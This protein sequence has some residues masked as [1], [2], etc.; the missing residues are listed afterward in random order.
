[1]VVLA[2]DPTLPSLLGLRECVVWELKLLVQPG[3]RG[4]SKGAMTARIA[5]EHAECG[6]APGSQNGYG[7]S[8][9]IFRSP[10]GILAFVA[11]LA[12][13]GTVVMGL[14]H[15]VWVARFCTFLARRRRFT[16]GL[17]WGALGSWSLLNTTWTVLSIVYCAA[18]LDKGPSTLTGFEQRRLL[19]GF[20]VAFAWA[21]MPQHMRFF[22]G[23]GALSRTMYFGAPEIARFMVGVA[24]IFLAFATLITVV[25]GPST[26]RWDGIQMTSLTMFAVATGDVMRETFVSTMY[27]VFVPGGWPAELFVVLLILLFCGIFMYVVIMATTAM[28]EETFLLTRPEAERAAETKS[29]VD[30]DPDHNLSPIQG[31]SKS[32]VDEI[33]KYERHLAANS[34]E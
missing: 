13:A 6:S 17:L 4:A 29:N 24:P 26:V 22:I 16:L 3:G 31:L 21:S 33:V 27:G 7:S 30:L 1:M 25:I 18:Y 19:Q 34:Q 9:D 8:L 2:G 11:L 14:S 23:A 5:T 28:M 12:A 20:A 32:L 10:P 15:L